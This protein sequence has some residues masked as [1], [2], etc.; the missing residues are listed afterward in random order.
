MSSSSSSADTPA[1]STPEQYAPPVVPTAEEWAAL[2]HSNT[3]PRMNAVI[4]ILVGISACFL[5]LRV[6][7]KFSRNKGL[8]WDDIFLIGAWIAIMIESAILSASTTLGYGLHIWDF[9]LA[10][11]PKLVIYL[12][13]AGTF[14]I[15]AAAWSKTSFAI[16]L[17]RL[18]HGWH[19]WVVWFIIVSVNVTMGLSA[20][21]PWVSCTP[22]QKS[23]DS[24]VPGTCWDPSIV[25]H[26]NTFSAAFS[27][28]M[29]I[30]LAM[31]PWVVIWNLQMKRNEKIGVAVAMSM[32]VFAG[33]TGIIKT[34]M[35][36]NMLSSDFADGLILFM[37]GNAESNVTIIAASI[38]IL[39]V[40]IRDAASSRRYYKSGQSGEPTNAN[41]KFTGAKH[42]HAVVT[43]SGGPLDSQV[44]MQ[45]QMTDDSSDRSILG[46]DHPGAPKTGPNGKIVQTQDFSVKYHTRDAKKDRDSDEYEMHEV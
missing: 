42:S 27:A 7:C 21:F 16:T 35:V 5:G 31:L 22:V 4:W 2:S 46:G 18:T 45:K 36:P 1:G 32:G 44:D 37:W 17:L 38:P 20:L 23:W 15:T 28:T 6:Y 9:N 40:L 19:K 26:Y 29:D 3:G 34:S 39:R 24:T 13:V 43:I 30:V 12:N 41:S 14:S 8:W 33:V 11:M 10:N 25:V